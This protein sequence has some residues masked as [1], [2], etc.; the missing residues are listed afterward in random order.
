VTDT[1][2]VAAGAAVEIDLIIRHKSMMALIAVKN[3]AFVDP[4]VM[5]L[6]AQVFS[7]RQ[8]AQQSEPQEQIKE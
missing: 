4:A 1:D 2:G 8:K 5:V 6:V 7:P 3:A